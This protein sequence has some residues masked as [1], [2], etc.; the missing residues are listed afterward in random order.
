MIRLKGGDPSIFGRCG[1][2][3]EALQQADVDFEIVPGVTAAS[4]AAAAAGISL[5]HRGIASSVV[6]L[7]GHR[8]PRN[9]DH[10]TER[11]SPPVFDFSGC[12]LAGKTV[13][14]YMP[15]P[16]HAILSAE[17]QAAGVPGRTP[18]ALVSAAS[19]ETQ[20]V[21]TTTVQKLANLPALVAPGIL[22][23]GDVARFTQ[24][25]VR[26]QFESGTETRNPAVFRGGVHQDGNQAREVGKTAVN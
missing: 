20:R 10:K 8:A 13:V 9:A 21:H 26:S 19:A 24:E 22:I 18:C 1:E 4:A 25:H 17:L 23:V 14:V 12:D 7:T 2:E 3:I 15:G 11:N 5:T 6:F 16:R